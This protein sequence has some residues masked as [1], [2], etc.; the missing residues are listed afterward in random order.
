MTTRMLIDA[1]HAEET[2]VVVLKGRRLEEFDVESSTKRQLKGNIYLAKV[3]RV[4]PSLQAAFVDYGG[5]RHGF[6]SFNE[7]HPDYYQIPVADREVLL[8]EEAEQAAAEAAEDDAAVE[9][10]ASKETSDDIDD[11]DI[12]DTDIDDAAVDEN[13][14]ED[15]DD[16]S[17]A[18]ARGSQADA[19]D[20]LDEVPRP[21]QR[22]KRSYK[23][24]E[25]IK[26]RQILLVQVVKEERGN[27]GAALT[28]YM[29]LAGRYCV[30]MPN[31]ARGGGISRKIT[32]QTAR[33]KLKKIVESLD[34][35]DGL[36][37]IVR[38]A[39][40]NR[41]KSDIKRDYEYLNRM[42]DQV[43]DL[44]LQSSAPA[45]VYEEAS[46]IKRSLRDLYNK[47]IEEILVD[48]EQGYRIAKDFMRMM[49][50]S[51]GKKVQHYG[52]RIPLFY[53][54]QVEQQLDM[55]H[56]STM[57]LRS[58]GTLVMNPTEALV[59][60]DVNSGKST[61]E[62]NIEET[63]LRTNLEAAEEIAR[64][65]RL[66]DLAGLI[67][68]DFIDMEENRNNRQVERRMKDCLK[69]DRA[70]IQVGRISMFGLLEM[71]RQRLRPSLVE[72]STITCPTCAGAGVVRSTESTALHVL[73]AI[74]EE[75]IRDRAAELSVTVPTEVALYMLNQ[76]RPAIEAIDERYEMRTF[77]LGDDTLVPPNFTLE[78]NEARTPRP[79]VTAPTE[80]VI[81]ADDDDDE[82]EDEFE[83]EVDDDVEADVEA[84]S[85]AASEAA[86]EVAS[87]DAD[88]GRK[89]RRRRRRPKRA[90]NGADEPAVEASEANEDAEV[91]S[92]DAADSD[93]EARTGEEEPGARRG[94]RRRGRR[95]GRRRRSGSPAED[96]ADATDT[97]AQSELA[98][99]SNE[100][101]G[102]VLAEPDIAA[103]ADTA[104]DAPSQ[105]DAEGEPVDAPLWSP[106]S[107]E[108]RE[109]TPAWAAPVVEQEAP[110]PA[111]WSA[112]IDDA[113]EPARQ[114]DV[115]EAAEVAPS[116]TPAWQSRYDAPPPVDDAVASQN[117]E[118][119]SGYG[120]DQGS[121]QPLAADS[122][123]NPP[124]PVSLPSGDDT[125][126]EETQEPEEPKRRGWWQRR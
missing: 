73:R 112:S 107:P 47:D 40:M 70:R 69:N 110:S 42:W 8:Q 58:G 122:A 27:K 17:E 11:T 21:R 23:I 7:I 18:E 114:E 84:A 71:S 33:R 87:E 88:S 24:Q 79:E 76:K 85:E 109:V 83:D 13:G 62:H 81:L 106:P 37:V 12:D 97:T 89:R 72:T 49:L 41:T 52:D 45:L 92:E 46:L 67:V 124:A 116:V 68:I 113:A 16:D 78:V 123:D 1:A 60:I 30:L 6:L 108:P 35:V 29:S 32:D 55:M 59:A 66:R 10:L 65:L 61:K 95:G 22:P 96:T 77:V 100:P 15:D 38:T 28:T 2:R 115:A 39:G 103:V 5:N 50:P 44:T 20:A 117:I 94:G 125:A 57:Q 34:V 119:E 31:T 63:A 126:P 9:L 118:V 26:R 82:F 91:E 121:A 54:Y 80:V 14:G 104:P 53:R 19:V 64:Q 98:P 120:P 3:T 56:S 4:E 86:P 93:V 101:D 48:G 36:G 51:H 102:S 99:D 25:V 90:P 105:P 75:G 43:R 74:E 111:P